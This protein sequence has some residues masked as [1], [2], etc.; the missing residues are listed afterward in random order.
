MRACL[1]SGCSAPPG[2]YTDSRYAFLR[3]PRLSAGPVD[4]GLRMNGR[5]NQVTVS[6]G[7]QCRPLPA[8]V[9]ATQRSSA[10]ELLTV[11][12]RG[13]SRQYGRGRG[14]GGDQTRGVAS[15][16]C[17]ACES[18]VARSTGPC[19]SQ[20]AVRSYERVIRSSAWLK[21]VGETPTGHSGGITRKSTT[22]AYRS[23]S[24]SSRRWT[25]NDVAC[26]PIPSADRGG[27]RKAHE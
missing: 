22:S 11:R 16:G 5:P 17:P 27:S 12:A 23:T 1:S 2:A 14:R 21:S 4:G 7:S 20:S 6:A 10:S 3:A 19:P 18:M 24:S 13:E 15:C 25:I 8:R 9:Y 26:R